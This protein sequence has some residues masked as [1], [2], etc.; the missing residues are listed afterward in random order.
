MSFQENRILAVIDPTRIEQWALQRAL[1]IGKNRTSPRIFAYLCAHS[2]AKCDDPERLRAVEVQR[3]RIW[4]D[5]VLTDFADAGIPIEPIVEWRAD[6][7]EGVCAAAET[8]Q[9]G[10]VIKRASGDPGALGN[11]D[12]R[13]IRGLKGSSLLVVKRNPV[14][15]LKNV[16]IAI[17]L[18]ATDRGH[19]ALNDSIVALGKRIRGNSKDL[20]L[21]SISAYEISEEFKHPPDIAK[22]LGISRSQAHVVQGSAAQV[23][24]KIA[25]RI[26]AD[27]VI[28]GNVARITVFER[29]VSD[30]IRRATATL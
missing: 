2:D 29:R 25:N 10:L 8:T 1:A 21:H 13:L 15:V 6:W 28:V 19:L 24:P 11:S 30:D 23:I 3:H 16:L 17:D 18:N 5:G 9:S 12:R 27:L 20:Q 26:H 22:T 4:L 14:K 7:R